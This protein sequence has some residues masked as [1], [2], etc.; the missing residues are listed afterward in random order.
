MITHYNS[1][2]IFYHMIHLSS[3]DTIMTLSINLDRCKCTITLKLMASYFLYIVKYAMLC[4]VDFH[5]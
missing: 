3:N 2:Q 5:G 1:T 4:V